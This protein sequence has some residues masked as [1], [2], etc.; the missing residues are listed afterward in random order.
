MKTLFHALIFQI[1]IILEIKMKKKFNVQS[2][3]F[4]IFSPIKHK[5]I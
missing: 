5:P 3:H 4:D 2:K 1:Y